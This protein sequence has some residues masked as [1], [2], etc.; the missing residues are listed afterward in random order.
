MSIS[1][2]TIEPRQGRY[3]KPPREYA[4][5]RGDEFLDIG[6]KQE[7]SK[8]YGLP[9]ATIEWLSTPSG[10]RRTGGKG[11]VIVRFDD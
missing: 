4:L 5:Y 11:W 10:S 8:K 9:V 6:T 7:L 1:Q 2:A 3:P